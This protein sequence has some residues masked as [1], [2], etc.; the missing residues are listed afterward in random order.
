MCIQLV[1][2]RMLCNLPCGTALNVWGFLNKPRKPPET[3]CSA[4]ELM[5]SFPK[6]TFPQTTYSSS[7][8]LS[9]IWQLGVNRPCNAAETETSRTSAFHDFHLL[10]G[11]VWLAGWMDGWMDG[12]HN[13]IFPLP[14][15]IVSHA[16]GKPSRRLLLLVSGWSYARCCFIGIGRLTY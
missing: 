7:T 9:F 2:T 15:R 6:H 3:S 16:A 4:A 13:N 8:K 11:R 1:C 5:S 10:D 12:W 14:L